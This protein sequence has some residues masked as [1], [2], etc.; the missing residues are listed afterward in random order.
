MIAFR[1]GDSEQP[2]FEDGVHAVPKRKRETQ[3]LVIVA[4]AGDAV[5]GPAI[6]AR[7]GVI[8]REVIPR[9]AVG[10]VVFARIA[11]GA[12]GQVRAP[13]PPVLTLCFELGAGDLVQLAFGGMNRPSRSGLCPF[14]D[15]L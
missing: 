13:A 11:P 1:A 15:N 10:A 12:F 4:D 7:A 9:R 8:V 6:G 5:L 2:L 3:A 14:Q